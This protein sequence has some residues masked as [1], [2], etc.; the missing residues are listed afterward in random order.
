MSG[1]FNGCGIMFFISPRCIAG[2]GRDKRT[3]AL[4]QQQ[5]ESGSWLLQDQT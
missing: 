1:Q 2:S 4:T 3:V 5:A